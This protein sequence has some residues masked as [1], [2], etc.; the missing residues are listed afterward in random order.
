MGLICLFLAQAAS[1][2][3]LGMQSLSVNAGLRNL[4]IVNSLLIGSANLYVLRTFIVVD[5]SSTSAT[6]AYLLGGP[7]GIWLCMWAH[8]R[9]VS[10]F[11]IFRGGK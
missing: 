1:V 7:A 5:T 3:L 2:F 9:I 4:A 11:K 6:I 8:P 10:R